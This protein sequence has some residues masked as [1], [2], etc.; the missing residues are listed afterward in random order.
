MFT[1]NRVH[2]P[3]EVEG[4]LSR[5]CTNMLTT[6]HIENGLA[7]TTSIVHACMQTWWLPT[8]AINYYYQHPHQDGAGSDIGYTFHN[9]ISD[10]ALSVFTKSS[11]YC[12]CLLIL[13]Q[14]GSSMHPMLSRGSGNMIPH[15]YLDSVACSLGMCYTVL[16]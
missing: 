11:C 2:D 1:N 16:Y 7:Y 15:H 10:G 8:T 3:L 12:H 14:R 9:F 4:A 6:M 5:L 13:R